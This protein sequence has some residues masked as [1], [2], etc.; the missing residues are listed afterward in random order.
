MSLSYAA[1]VHNQEYPELLPNELVLALARAT[2]HD[3]FLIHQQLVLANPEV[4]VVAGRPHLLPADAATTLL[5]LDTRLVAT[6]ERLTAGPTAG[7]SLAS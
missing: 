4:H 3:H 7:L 5:G 6:V 2:G 1:F